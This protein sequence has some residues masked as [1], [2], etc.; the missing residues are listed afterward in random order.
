MNPIAS[1]WV[2]LTRNL[3]AGFH[4]QN[5][6]RHEDHPIASSG[7]FCKEN[8]VNGFLVQ[9]LFCCFLVDSLRDKTSRGRAVSPSS[10]PR[11]L[12]GR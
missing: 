2:I 11:R 1:G 12:N 8:C 4:P 5:D 10:R 7:W 9:F 6:I 3:V